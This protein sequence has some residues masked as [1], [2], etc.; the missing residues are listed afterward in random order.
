MTK[1]PIPIIQPVLIFDASQHKYSSTS[2]LH[3][4]TMAQIIH[5]LR[6]RTAIYL[7]VN[8]ETQRNT[9]TGALA[10][11]ISFDRHRAAVDL[12][13]AGSRARPSSDEQY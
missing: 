1:Q 4:A 2:L 12:N 11:G 5:D 6:N 3:R 13:A 7:L 10:N 8:N 9:L